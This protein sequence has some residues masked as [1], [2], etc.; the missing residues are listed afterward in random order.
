MRVAVG[1]GSSQTVC[2]MPLTAVPDSLGLA[3]L[4]AA[5]LLVVVGGIQHLHH[6]LLLT[7]FQIRG[8]VKRESRIASGMLAGK[9]P[10]HPHLCTPVHRLEIQPQLLSLP[11]F[12]DGKS[13]AVPE[14]VIGRD[15]F[16]D[17]GEGALD[18]K[19]NQNLPLC[20]RLFPVFRADGIVPQAVERLP[21]GAFQL[22]TR[23]FR[24][25]VQGVHIGRPGAM[26]MV[27]KR[28]PVVGFLF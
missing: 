3:D 21:Q 8:D 11:L 9:L 1:V 22:R 15:V 25:R 19:R 27:R 5:G 18:G 26:D 2:Q 12:G 7:P 17:A 14:G 4:L 20:R 28:L 6:Q 23:I 13:G 24:E 16:S 10:V